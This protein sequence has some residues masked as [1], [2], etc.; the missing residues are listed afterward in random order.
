MA[1]HGLVHGV[2]E[3]LGDE[4]MQGALVG[5]ADEHARAP[6]DRL[7]AL[8]HLDV[9]GGVVEADGALHALDKVVHGRVICR[10]HEA[11]A[12]SIYGRKL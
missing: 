11:M 4:V 12:S 9:G 10:A 8:E 3:Q 2:V 7:Q 5:A 1:G 6:A